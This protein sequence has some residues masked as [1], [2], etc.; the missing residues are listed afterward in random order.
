MIE[1]SLGQDD[2]YVE[3]TFSKVMDDLGLEATSEQYGEAFEKIAVSPV[4]C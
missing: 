3:M 2:L 4:A 1:N